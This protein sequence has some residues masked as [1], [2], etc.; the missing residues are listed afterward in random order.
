MTPVEPASDEKIV[1]ILTELEGHGDG[2]V[3]RFLAG[4]IRALIV[5][6]RAQEWQPISSIPIGAEM[7]LSDG[8]RMG[9]GTVG[10]GAHGSNLGIVWD[11]SYATEPTHY[12][13]L[14]APPTPKA[15]GS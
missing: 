9:V 8:K 1:Q 7:L 15:A 12:M 3:E 14:P 6:I 5:R 13:P 10:P 4:E 2:Y 11:W